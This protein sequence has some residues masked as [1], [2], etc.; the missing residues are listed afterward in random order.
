M[1]GCEDSF[2]LC[3][4]V[5]FAL[6]STFACFSLLFA[7]FLVLFLVFCGTLLAKLLELRLLLFGEVEAFEGIAL[8]LCTFTGF[9]AGCFGA[10]GGCLSGLLSERGE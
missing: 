5:L 10:R 4:I 2:D 9:V 6:F 3:E 1:F 8:A 7:C